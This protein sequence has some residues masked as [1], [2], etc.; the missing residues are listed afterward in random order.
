VNQQTRVRPLLNLN[1]I[2]YTRFGDEFLVK[3][4][5]GDGGIKDAIFIEK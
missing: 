2:K 4:Y 1:V 3:G 5:R